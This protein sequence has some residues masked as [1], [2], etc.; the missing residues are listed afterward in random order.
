MIT[1]QQLKLSIDVSSQVHAAG[2]MYECVHGVGIG[3]TSKLMTLLFF[4]FFNFKS[5]SIIY[6]SFFTILIIYL[7]VF[8]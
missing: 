2:P 3:Y 7:L 6:T 4:F 8:L 5:Y 1:V